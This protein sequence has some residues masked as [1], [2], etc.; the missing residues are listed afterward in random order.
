MTGPRLHISTDALAPLLDLIQGLANPQP[1]TV[2][3][4]VVD[5]NG[6]ADVL[7]CS[8]LTLKTEWQGY[9]HIFI[10]RGRKSSRSVRFRVSDVLAY[11]AHRDYTEEQQ[12]AIQEQK[13]KL[14]GGASQNNGNGECIQFPIRSATLEKETAQGGHIS[15][16]ERSVQRRGQTKVCNPQSRKS[17]GKRTRKEG[18]PGNN[19]GDRHNLRRFCR[20]IP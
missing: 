18:A 8:P 1:Q 17:M 3:N 7:G 12:D 20:E 2:E 14:L 13:T 6:L 10:G 4:Q 19:G 9:P 15:L 11:L 16:Q 5:I